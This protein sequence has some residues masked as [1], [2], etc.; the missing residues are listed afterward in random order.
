V[1]KKNM[2][3]FIIGIFLCLLQFTSSAQIQSS[4][5]GIEAFGGGS[6][7]G[8]TFGGELKFAA[9]L[10]NNLIIGPSFRLQRSWSNYLNMQTQFTIY[11][12]GAFA[13]MRYQDKIFAGVEFQMLHSPFNFITF[14][15][16]QKKW[17]PTLFVG[18]GFYL[19][20]TPK[21]NLN[22][23]LFYDVINAD[24]SPFRSSYNFRIKN[25]FGQVVRILPIIYR[26]TLFIPL[27]K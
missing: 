1:E 8:G 15:S 12:G 6:Q 27:T 20:L 9:K 5:L 13:H 14:Q 24:N 22:L 7:L 18:G 4:E 3:H 11:G 21:I 16:G 19:K 25:E 17:A 23:A 10:P 2:K 26:I